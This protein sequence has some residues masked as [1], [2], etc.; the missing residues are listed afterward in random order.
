MEN[1]DYIVVGAGSAGCVL[2]NRLSENPNNKVLLLE[3][4]GEDRHLF[5][6]IPGG[7]VKLVGNRRGN[8]QLATQPQPHMDG[9][10]LYWPRGKVLGGSSSINAMVYT[11]GHAQ[12]YDD[13]ADL[14]L[15]DWSYQ[16]IL[17][18]FRRSEGNANGASTYHGGDG[19]LS[20]SNVPGRSLLF[21]AFIQAGVQAGYLR[22]HDFNGVVQEGVGPFQ[23]TTR[24]NKRCSAAVA[25]LHPIRHRSNLCV[26]TGAQT[27]KIRFDGTKA[28]G[29]DYIQY[30]RTHH[31]TAAREVILTAGA[32]HSPQL[33]LV[34]GI[35]PSQDLQ[36]H[37]IACVKHLPGVG[38]NLQDH[39]CCMVIHTCSQ[40]VSLSEQTKTINVISS[41]LRFLMF[42]TG[43][44]VS[45]GIESGAF[46]RS[47]FADARPDI[48]IHMIAAAVIDHG[49]GRSPGHA[50]TMDVSQMRPQSRGF[51][52][53]SSPDMRDAPLIQPNYLDS[54]LDRA[55]M[56]ASVRIAHNIAKQPA[57]A[58]Y[59]DKPLHPAG[60]VQSDSEIDAWIR[61][62]AE[63]GY[64]PV[65]TAKMG[66]ASDPMA[67][68][69]QSGR[70]FGTS[71]LRVSDASLM[72][73]LVGGNTNAPT[74]MM[75]EK[76]ADDI[77]R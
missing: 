27:M 29:V 68:T 66:R 16:K 61:S 60:S 51:L 24:N 67:V 11:R 34:S 20:V 19:P 70:V 63:T 9:R 38:Q 3:A 12:D 21:N 14:G 1:W 52:A 48:Q 26:R 5:Y 65:G 49:R 22:N 42:G 73:L 35:G 39:L 59:T 58:A 53:L 50:Y 18:Y 31:A 47:G 54:E 25:Y 17:P 43:P 75:A 8:W 77:L 33:L 46:I 30:G 62:S 2:A 56:R 4:G 57:L 44:A 76:I 71:N 40:A 37:G 23:L 74:I 64:H 45:N 55:V 15:T 10:R 7:V 41:G 32:V 13:W 6:K 36:K 69:D 28:T 72:P